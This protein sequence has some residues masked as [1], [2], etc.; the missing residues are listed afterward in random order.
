MEVGP[1]RDASPRGQG[2]HRGARLPAPSGDPVLRLEGSSPAELL[3]QKPNV[4]IVLNGDILDRFVPY[5]EHWQRDYHGNHPNGAP[6]T[7]EIVVDKT[8]TPAR[9]ERGGDAR[10]LAFSLRYLAWGPE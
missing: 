3:P 5:E 1:L 9:D 6:A 7:L 10:A 2:R 4:T 8:Y